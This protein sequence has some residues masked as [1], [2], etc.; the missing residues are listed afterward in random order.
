M[1]GIFTGI[2]KILIWGCQIAT[3]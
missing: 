1:Q 2:A 3:K